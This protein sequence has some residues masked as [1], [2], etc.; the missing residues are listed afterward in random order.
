MADAATTETPGHGAPQGAGG[1]PQFDASWWPGEM[2][3][4]LIIFVVVFALMAK[5]FVPRV[6][7]TIAEREDRISGDIGRARAL[8]EQAEAQAAQADAEMVQARSRAQKVAADAKAKAQAEAAVRQAQE[9]AK[10]AESL[11]AAE[12]GIQASRE[13]AMGH[14]REIAA[15]TAQVI[16][17]KLTGQAASAKDID[18]AL[19]G[20]A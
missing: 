8:K 9:E 4:F 10:L 20:R 3:W 16:V 19:A 18:A 17:A 14:V 5:V 13:S 6:G 7:G 12:A 2:A 11:A 15:E 1:L